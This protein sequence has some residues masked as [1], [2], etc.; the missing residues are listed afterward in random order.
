MAS[1]TKV[2]AS[3]HQVVECF[4]TRRTRASVDGSV[5]TTGNTLCVGPYHVAFW[6]QGTIYLVEHESPSDVVKTI[7]AMVKLWGHGH[8]VAEMRVND[9]SD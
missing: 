7:Q 1:V 6:H 3:R 5:H 2:E 4:I 8:K 9:G